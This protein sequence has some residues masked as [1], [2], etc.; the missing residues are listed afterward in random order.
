M[1]TSCIQVTTIQGRINEYGMTEKAELANLERLLREGFEKLVSD[2]KIDA[3]VTLGST[4][5]TLLLNGR[6]PG[7]NVSAGYDSNVFHLA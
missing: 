3:L 2:Y 6:F 1:F 5:A 4:V 7:I